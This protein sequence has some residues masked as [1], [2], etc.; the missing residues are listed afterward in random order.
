MP[1]PS[2]TSQKTAELLARTKRLLRDTTDMERKIK[3]MRAELT[4][5]IIGA[6]KPRASFP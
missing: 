3:Q 1:D 5:R 6:A 4:P 2:Y